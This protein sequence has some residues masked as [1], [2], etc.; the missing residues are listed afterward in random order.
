MKKVAAF[1]G[2]LLILAI[3]GALIAPFFIDLNDYKPEIAEQ[4]KAATGRDLAIDGDI[5]LS[6]LPMPSVSVAGVHFGNAAGGSRPDMLTL[7]AVSVKVALMPLLSGQIQVK[8][9]I[10]TK[11]DILLEKLADNPARG[12]LAQRSAEQADVGARRGHRP[13]DV[14]SARARRV[15]RHLRCGS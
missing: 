14:R 4:A 2:A 10:L 7:E 15:A 12:W 8:E 6:L 1:L 9:V 13:D 3:A 11:P 5:S